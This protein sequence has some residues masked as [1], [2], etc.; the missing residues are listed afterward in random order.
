M[1]VHW[2]TVTEAAVDAKQ[3]FDALEQ[4]AEHSTFFK[5]AL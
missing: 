2:E 5:R 1:I 3:T 4:K